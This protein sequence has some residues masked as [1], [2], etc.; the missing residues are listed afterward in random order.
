MNSN[1]DNLLTRLPAA[2]PEATLRAACLSQPSCRSSRSH[3]LQDAHQSAVLALLRSFQAASLYPDGVVSVQSPMSILVSRSQ[4][5]RS[6]AGS[7]AHAILIDTE[8]LSGSSFPSLSIKILMAGDVRAGSLASL[9]TCPSA[10]MGVTA[11]SLLR[12][13]WK[14]FLPLL[15][16]NAGVS[17]SGLMHP[18]DDVRLALAVGGGVELC[19]NLHAKN[20]ASASIGR[21][22]PRPT[23]R[24][25]ARCSFAWDES[26][27]L[28]TTG[29]AVP[30]AGAPGGDDA[31]FV[32]EM[33]TPL[34]P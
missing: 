1:I 13:P 33:F 4:Q 12:A 25:I 14:S 2:M 29:G 6:P 15:M 5:H 8:G 10:D 16:I 24:P 20:A 26:L 27:S 11:S 3:L 19:P 31:V 28:G 32:T 22:T 23:P 30:G 18:G 21:P 17:G 7:R 9:G 34:A